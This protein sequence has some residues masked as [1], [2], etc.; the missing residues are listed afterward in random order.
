MRLNVAVS[1]VVFCSVGSWFQMRGPAMEKA[2]VSKA[3]GSSTRNWCCLNNYLF[4]VDGCFA[5]NS[6]MNKK[7]EL[8]FNCLLDQ[9]PVKWL[10]CWRHVVSSRGHKPFSQRRLSLT[11]TVRELMQG[12]CYRS[13]V[14]TKQMPRLDVLLLPGWVSA[15]S[16]QSMQMVEARTC[17]STDVR[18][19]PHIKLII[20]DMVRV[21]KLNTYLLMSNFMLNLESKITL[22]S[23]IVKA[24]TLKSKIVKAFLYWNLYWNIELHLCFNFRTCIVWASHQLLAVN[25]INYWCATSCWARSQ[26]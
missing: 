13:Q 21:T 2:I 24:N 16:R 12:E 9:K 6:Q 4:E 19:A 5:V 11:A 10:K 23:K 18:F 25:Y 8:E 20:A 15:N 3:I 7:A 17:Y 14:V 22:N 1:I 26:K